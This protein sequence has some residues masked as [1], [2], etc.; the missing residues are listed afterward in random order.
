MFVGEPCVGG[1]GDED[2]TT[3]ERER[4]RFSW[5]RAKGGR[6]RARCAMLGGQTATNKNAPGASVRRV[7]RKTFGRTDAK[8][9]RC[10]ISRHLQRHYFDRHPRT[11]VLRITKPPRVLTRS[12]LGG[13]AGCSGSTREVGSEKVRVS[14]SAGKERAEAPPS[15]SAVRGKIFQ[16]GCR[17]LG[18]FRIYARL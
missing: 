11:A 4:E 6:C 18:T 8:R 7:G 15:S 5:K 9:K 16:P 13:G 2:G 17:L 3:Q 1:D 12:W 14:L 10:C